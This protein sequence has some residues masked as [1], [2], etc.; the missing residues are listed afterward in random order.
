MFKMIKSFLSWC[1]R[2]EYIKV[3][4][5]T[6]VEAPKVPRKLLKGFTAKEMEATM[7]ASFYK[8]TIWKLETKPY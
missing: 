8:K 5:A 7:E 1:E 2:E 4:V 6:K 3:N